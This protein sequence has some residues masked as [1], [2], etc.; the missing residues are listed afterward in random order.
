MCSFIIVE[1]G[2][3]VACPTV[4]VYA[5]GQRA[6]YMHVLFGLG[7]VDTSDSTLLPASRAVGIYASALID[8]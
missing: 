3:K 5:V 4:C 1:C 8:W 2:G 7:D 6:I